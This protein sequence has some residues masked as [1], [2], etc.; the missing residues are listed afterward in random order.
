MKHLSKE[1]F[2]LPQ[3]ENY[4]CIVNKMK[5]AKKNKKKEKQKNESH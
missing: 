1:F 2:G 3:D 4:F 5:R